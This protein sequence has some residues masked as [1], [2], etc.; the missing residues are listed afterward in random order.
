MNKPK[1]ILAAFVVGLLALL[2]E[3]VWT[4]P[5]PPEWL[6]KWTGWGIAFIGLVKA[7]DIALALVE[8]L[9]KS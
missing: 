2:L 7:P 1:L 6:T 3:Y 5:L 8:H 4:P 9:K